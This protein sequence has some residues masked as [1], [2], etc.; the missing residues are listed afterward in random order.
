MTILGLQ[1][2][3]ELKGKKGTVTTRAEVGIDQVRPEQFD[4]LFI[5]GGYSPGP[6]SGRCSRSAMGLS[7]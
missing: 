6:S 4:A 1:P 7:C 2:G 5:P 3:K